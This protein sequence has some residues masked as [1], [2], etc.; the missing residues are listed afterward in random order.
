MKMH[1]LLVIV[2]L[3]GYLFTMFFMDIFA[4]DIG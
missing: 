2:L 3:G 4:L 1:V